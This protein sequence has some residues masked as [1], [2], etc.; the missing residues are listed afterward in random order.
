MLEIV[1]NI[2]TLGYRKNNSYYK[3]IS[4][5]RIKLSRPQNEARKIT[6]SE[7]DS[8]PFLPE[9][10]KYINALD[11]TTH[12]TSI[13][14]Q[15]LDIFMNSIRHFD[16]RLMLFKNHYKTYSDNILRLN[17]SSKNKNFDLVVLQEFLK[18]NSI[19]D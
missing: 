3:L 7:I 12:K 2:L 19:K 14:E 5:F 15:D 16:Y 9:S 18:D 8:N 6:D 17:P 10:M 13:T 1:L 11:L 4:E